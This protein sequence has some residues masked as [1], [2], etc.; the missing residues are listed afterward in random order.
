MTDLAQLEAEVLAE[1]AELEPGFAKCEPL[2]WIEDSSIGLPCHLS[3][4]RLE[5]PR[6]QWAV[7]TNRRIVSLLLVRNIVRILRENPDHPQAA[8]HWH[9]AAFL[10]QYGGMVRL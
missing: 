8:E 5:F 3:E 1:F 6:A 10:L 7:A 4:P 9:T 2:N